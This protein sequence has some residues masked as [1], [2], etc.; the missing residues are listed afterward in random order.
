M[1]EMKEKLATVSCVVFLN[2]PPR[3]V[4]YTAS[5]AEYRCNGISGGRDFS[6]QRLKE[7]EFGI[8]LDFEAL[9]ELTAFPL[10][11]EHLKVQ[12]A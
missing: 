7:E 9:A 2:M 11:L 6:G 8:E 12:V 1:D 3:G 4:V 10:I 5:Q